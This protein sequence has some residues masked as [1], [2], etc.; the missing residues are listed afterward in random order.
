L[1]YV[2]VGDPHN[3]K[4]LAAEPSCSAF[5]IFD[6]RCVAIAVDFDDQFRFSAEEVGDEWA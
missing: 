5:V 3:P 2:R 6:L 1:H 4:A